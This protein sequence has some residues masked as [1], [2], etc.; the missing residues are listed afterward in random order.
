M[1]KRQKILYFAVLTALTAVLLLCLYKIG[2]YLRST[3][4]ARRT[5]A[6]LSDQYVIAAEGGAA[7]G[8]ERASAAGASDGAGTAENA[9]NAVSVDFASL[10]AI[11]PDI[12]AWIRFDH[13]DVIPIDYPILCPGD[14]DAYIHTDLYGDHSISGSIFLDETNSPDFADDSD[15]SKLIYGHNMK[16]GDMF[17]SLRKYRSGGMLEDNRYF[18]I[19]TP[20]KSY[21]YRIFSYFVTK[22]G[23]FVYQTGL[24]KNTEAYQKYLEQLK[25]AS[26]ESTDIRPSADQQTAILSTCAESRSDRRFVICGIRI[27]P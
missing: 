23:S 6:A 1:T 22:T 7:A 16:S 20:E 15:F 27:D 11:N 26:M 4:H 24:A 10:Q 25:E 21:R 17:G 8:T 3:G 19:Y 2:S 18:S 14:N 9:A 12:R 5:F 13:P